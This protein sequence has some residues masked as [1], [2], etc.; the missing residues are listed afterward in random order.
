MLITDLRM[1]HVCVL[2]ADPSGPSFQTVFNS[3]EQML[4]VGG[5]RFHSSGNGDI[6]LQLAHFWSL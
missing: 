4:K 6:Y 1:L 3:T 2:Q 5:G